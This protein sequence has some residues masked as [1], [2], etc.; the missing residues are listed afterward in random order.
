MGSRCD[1]IDWTHSATSMRKLE[2]S[3]EYSKEPSVSMQCYGMYLQSY[4]ESSLLAYSDKDINLIA[5]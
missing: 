4:L 5:T 3:Y 1:F 2:G